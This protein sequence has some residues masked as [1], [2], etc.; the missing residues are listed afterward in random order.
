M[1]IAFSAFIH[2]GL[3]ITGR[4]FDIGIFKLPYLIASAV[5]VTACF[6]V[7]ECKEYWHFLLCQGFAIGVCIFLIFFVVPK[8]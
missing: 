5:L 8:H 1:T 6:L 2:S 3:Y 7:A 4:L